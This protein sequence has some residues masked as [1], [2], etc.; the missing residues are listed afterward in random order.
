LQRASTVVE[1]FFSL[2]FSYFCFFVA[3]LKHH[4]WDQLYVQL[5]QTNCICSQPWIW[6]RNW[7][8]VIIRCM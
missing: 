3:A 7:F 5:S 2:I 1:D 6:A 8:C 4:K